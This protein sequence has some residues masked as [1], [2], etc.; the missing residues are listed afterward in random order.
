VNPQP[1]PAAASLV[2]LNRVSTSFGATRAVQDVT[3]TARAGTIHALVG[4]N[5]AGKSTL[6]RILAGAERPD[7]GELLLDGRPLILRRPA[8][9]LRAGIAMVYQELSLA[10]HLTVAENVFLGHE[11][12]RWGWFERGAA[13]D[14]VLRLARESSIAVDPTSRVGRLSTAQR[15]Q[16]EILRALA[17]GARVL[18]MDEPT[19]S[20]PA[21]DVE[22]LIAMLQRL[23]D[24]GIV[25]FY[26]SHKLEEIERLADALSVLRDGQLVYSGAADL[27]R[28]QI[29]RHMVGREMTQLYPP[30][31]ARTIGAERL[32]TVMLTGNGFTDVSLSL[33]A[34]EV[35]GLAGLVGAGRSQVAAALAGVE[36]ATRGEIRLDG[37]PVALP[38][39]A[40]AIRRGLGLLTEDRRGTGVFPHLSIA[41]NMSIAA[42]RRFCCA[43]V[44]RR[45]REAVATTEL[46]DAVN[47]KRSRMDARV[48]SLSGGN[49]Q[50]T[51]LGRWLLAEAKVLILD[52]PTRGVDVGAKYEI[53]GLIGQLAARGL[54]L[55]VISSEL[56]ELFGVTD[57]ILVMCR[58]R[59]T[60]D[61]RTAATSPDEVMHCATLPEDQAS[62]T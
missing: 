57:R 36:P 54:A 47:L 5:G 40:A 49:Q 34:G 56:P 18:I 23:R 27:G 46:A 29:I 20:L 25:V 32:A 52:E 45:G 14:L 1:L 62:S 59:L 15:Q 2:S 44:I 24:R 58:G 6:M 3:L 7:S 16:I 39:P 22:H 31:P 35:V 50:K 33:R 17:H 30:R 8:D 9:A 55:L 38:S 10:P 53:Y 60:A 48:T 11:P 41:A 13:N 28:P 21:H 51:L 37:K 12:G 4:E 61:L 43:G 26:I 42:L 19:S